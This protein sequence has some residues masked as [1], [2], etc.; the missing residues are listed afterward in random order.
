[1][2]HTR[3]YSSVILGLTIQ[4]EGNQLSSLVDLSYVQAAFVTVKE[5]IVQI[6]KWHSIWLRGIWLI[7]RRYSHLS[8]FQYFWSQLR[9]M[10]Y[11]YGKLMVM[12]AIFVFQ[13][14]I[15]LS[16]FRLVLGYSW[17][18]FLRLWEVSG[19]PAELSIN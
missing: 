13:F 10:N 18:S 17:S 19:L 12:L 9:I 6:E 8:D 1:M 15:D 5:S 4:C 2:I 11:S 3:N 14:E 7:Q 16:S